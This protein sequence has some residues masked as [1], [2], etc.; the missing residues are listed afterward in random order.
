MQCTLW[1][2][3]LWRFL[4][5]SG[6]IVIRLI[7]AILIPTRQPLHRQQMLRLLLHPAIHL[8]LKLL[9]SVQSM[10]KSLMVASRRAM[11]IMI[12]R[13]SCWRIRSCSC[14]VNWRPSRGKSEK[15]R[16][17]RAV[18]P[19]SLKILNQSVDLQIHLSNLKFRVHV[20][21]RRRWS[22]AR[23]HLRRSRRFRMLSQSFQSLSWV[24]C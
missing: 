13:C 19:A 8:L 18:D 20:S 5:R 7:N 21:K 3:E 9:P 11:M 17:R 12:F 14:R 23:L 10:Q 6:T 1:A 16:K 24:L 22:F 15:T 2:R 4:R